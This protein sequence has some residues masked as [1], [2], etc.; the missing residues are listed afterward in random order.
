MMSGQI[1]QEDFS[2][3]FG[4]IARLDVATIDQI[5][6]STKFPKTTLKHKLSFYVKT[7][8]LFRVAK[9]L[10]SVTPRDLG[11]GYAGQ[12]RRL[13]EQREDSALIAN[14]FFNM[15]RG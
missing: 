7:G 4:V 15:V 10:Y 8:R 9:G 11:K 6:N 3:I 12:R 14:C 1:N 5:A 2:E 13:K